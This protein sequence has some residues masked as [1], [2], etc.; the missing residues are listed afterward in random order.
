MFPKSTLNWTCAHDNWLL[1]M[2][3][4]QIGVL[5]HNR[6][7]VNMRSQKE[8]NTKNIGSVKPG[9]HILAHRNALLAHAILACTHL[10]AHMHN[11]NWARQATIEAR[12]PFCNAAFM[13]SVQAQ[14][15]GLHSLWQMEWVTVSKCSW[16]IDNSQRSTHFRIRFTTVGY[17]SKILFT[18][19]HGS[20][21]GRLCSWLVY[22][23][24]SLFQSCTV[25]SFTP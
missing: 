2:T 6:V 3:N 10:Q 1:K 13:S 15:F 8:L 5:S 21:F 20:A 24:C 11:R 18:I 23:L 17:T 12:S 14:E 25:A 16:R 19:Q 9:F 7:I 22:A 4:Q